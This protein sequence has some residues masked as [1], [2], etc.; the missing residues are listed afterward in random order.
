[1]NIEFSRQILKLFCIKI[2]HEIPSSGIRVIPK[3][4]QEGT[5]KMKVTFSTFDI[6][7]IGTDKHK[8]NTSSLQTVATVIFVK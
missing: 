8:H 1:M 6:P 4:W 5:A 3:L 7:L 2:Y